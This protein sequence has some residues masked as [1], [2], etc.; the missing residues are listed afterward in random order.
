M[1]PLYDDQPI[2]RFPFVTIFLI[3][4]NVLVF[5]GWQ[6]NVGMDKSVALGGLVPATLLHAPTPEHCERI[7]TAMFLHGG[8]LHL[9]GNMWFLWIFGNNIEDATGSLRFL[10]FYLLCGIA[11]AMAHIFFAPHSHTPMIG[12]S[13][14]ISGV[15]GAYLVLHPRA[16]ITTLV[17][18]FIFI[19]IMEI[20]AWFFLLFW[21]GLQILSQA[22]S[23]HTGG[24]GVAY[25]AHIGGFFA[26]VPL[27][28]FFKKQRR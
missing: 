26:G 18:L 25:L 13:G 15:L 11:A 19:R 3:A 1:L 28:F 22:A 5:T 8:W 10:L 14:A 27:I 12:A 4:L 23:P 21:I 24:G 9:V 20:P 16:A 2:K 17:P 7:V 6:L